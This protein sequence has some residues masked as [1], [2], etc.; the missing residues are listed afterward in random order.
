MTFRLQIDY[1]SVISSSADLTKVFSADGDVYPGLV[2]SVEFQARPCRQHSLSTPENN[3][4][5]SNN[6]K[7]A[8]T[9]WGVLFALEKM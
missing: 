4:D 5:G 3:F 2:L 1:N 8:V 7:M 9:N 6:K